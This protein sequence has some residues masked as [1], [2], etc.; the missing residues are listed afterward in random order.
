MLPP[1]DAALPQPPRRRSHAAPR[2][3]DLVMD[4]AGSNELCVPGAVRIGGMSKPELLRALR[5]QGVLLN[6][7]AEALFEDVRFTTLDRQHVVPIVAVSVAGLGF[8][9]GAVHAQIVARARELG[10]AECPLELGP[11]L[12]L[13]FPDQPCVDE[14]PR[15]RGRAPRG[16]LT[17]A[18]PPLDDL[19]ETPKGFYLRRTTDA[20]WLR[21]YWSWPGHVWSAE[22]VL[23]FA[24]Q[25]HRIARTHP[26]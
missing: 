4:Q 3:L 18:S 8:G 23:V 14:D 17:I 15:T 10:L 11:H 20:C 22:D 5:E 24:G 12:R 9:E 25:R 13:Q 26:A 16:A 21:G 7:A 19:D 2:R 1:Q 6:V